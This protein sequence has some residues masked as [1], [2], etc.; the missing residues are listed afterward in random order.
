[1]VSLSIFMVSLSKLGEKILLITKEYFAA[2]QKTG[3]N[4]QTIITTPRALD[5]INVGG[6]N[7][8]K[9]GE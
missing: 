6:W 8:I 7:I 3:N 1:M 2:L 5:N 4:E 9:M